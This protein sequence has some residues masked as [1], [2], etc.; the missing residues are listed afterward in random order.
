MFD[1]VHLRVA[2][3]AASRAFYAEVLEP[4]GIPLLLDAPHL[5]GFANLAISA[6]GPVSSNVHV[7]F[8]AADRAAVDA[9][10]A[11]GLAAGHRDNGAPGVRDYGPPGMT[12]YAAYLLDPDGNNI[13]AV[14]RSFGA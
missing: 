2:D 5:L 13:E 7:A 11:A 1:H 4:L 6:D 3:L 14:H 9:F 8:T 12:W 10:H